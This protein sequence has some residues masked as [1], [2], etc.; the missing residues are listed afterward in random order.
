MEVGYRGVGLATS[1][2]FLTSVC[3]LLVKVS[4]LP[5]G[6]IWFCGLVVTLGAALPVALYRGEC[7]FPRGRRLMLFAHSLACSP[8]LLATYQAVRLMPLADEAVLSYSSIVFTVLL[9]GLWLG[10]PCGPA[11]V[12]A[13]LLVLSGVVLLAGPSADSSSYPHYLLG[14]ALS[15]GGSLFDSVSCVFARKLVGLHYSVV[16]VNYSAVCLVFSCCFA[17]VEEWTFPASAV[18]PCVV[19]VAVLTALQESLVTSALLV[20]EAGLVALAQT[21]DVAFAYLWE[22][23]FFDEGYS[24][25]RISGAVVIVS[26][27]VLSAFHKRSA[28]RNK[29]PGK[30]FLV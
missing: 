9:A 7:L 10:E 19:S 16:L 12:S 20:E 17:F 18:T 11:D 23:V 8:L 14:A 28:F 5:P 22:L 29:D 30:E 4:S 25:V 1:S 21:S 2:A 13:S 6:E 15:L 27:V 26:V 24:V 3:C